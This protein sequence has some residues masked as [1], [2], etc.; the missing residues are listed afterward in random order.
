MKLGERYR[1]IEWSWD[2]QRMFGGEGFCGRERMSGGEGR[3]EDGRGG[4]VWWW[5]RN[6]DRQG[7]G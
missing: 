1:D 3:R 2:R 7:C 4:E 5:E 6:E